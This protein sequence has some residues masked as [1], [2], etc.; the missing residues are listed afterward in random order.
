MRWAANGLGRLCCGARFEG[1]K[2]DIQ[3]NGKIDQEFMGM[4]SAKQDKTGVKSDS[5]RAGEKNFHPATLSGRNPQAPT[6]L[7]ARWSLSTPPAWECLATPTLQPRQLKLT[8]TVEDKS[9]AKEA[10]R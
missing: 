5:T 7:L 2:V 8:V 10:C 9:Q 4:Q 6:I 3:K 1:G